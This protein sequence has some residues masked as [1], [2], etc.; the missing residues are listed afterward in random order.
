MPRIVIFL[1]LDDTILQT[2]PKCPPGE[3]VIPAAMD[4][5]GRALSFMTRAQQRLLAFWLDQGTV[6]PVTGRTDDA[7]ARVN[8]AF[9]SWR[10]THH[11]AVIRQPNGFLPTWWYTQVRPLL[12]AAQ[13]LLWS[14]AARLTTDATAGG[15]RVSSH[16]VD[17]WL[18]YVS[19]KSNDEGVALVRVRAQLQKVGL[20]PELTLHC[21]G[22]N[23]AITVKGAQKQDAVR[24]VVA[25]LERDGP[26]VTIGAGDSLTDIPFLRACDFALVPKDSQIQTE[27]W[28]GSR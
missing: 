3:A 9:T 17:E 11:G 6:I 13:P 16:S 18:T 2:A 23:L 24:R 22:N 19:V 12:V 25:E 1:D 7:L 27:T 14:L 20:P 10:I 15:Y 21:N 4:R 26:I 5:T 28:S 8:I